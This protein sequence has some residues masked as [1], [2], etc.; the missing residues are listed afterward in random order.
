M[1]IINEKEKVLLDLHPSPELLAAYCNHDLGEKIMISIKKHIEL[2]PICRQDID[3][4]NYDFI[5]ISKL[6]PNT[7]PDVSNKKI[8]DKIEL[9]A[10]LESL[11]DEIIAKCAKILLPIEQHGEIDKEIKK[12]HKYDTI[13]NNDSFNEKAF[14]DGLSII[15]EAII[16]LFM[17]YDNIEEIFL[18]NTFENSVEEAF[19]YEII[20]TD[21]H[22]IKLLKNIF[23]QING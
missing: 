23:L 17:L 11:K 13:D 12:Y 21:R 4:L 15:S 20:Q 22:K 10:K 5:E 16:E 18:S 6:S 19:T 14:I 3:S 1:S 2:C 9:L 7:S 8:N